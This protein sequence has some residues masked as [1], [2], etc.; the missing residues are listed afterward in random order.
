MKIGFHSHANK[1]NSHMKSKALSLT[2]TMRLR[3]AKKLAHL[4]M[5]HHEKN[6]IRQ[7]ELEEFLK[8]PATC[9]RRLFSGLGE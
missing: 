1:T 5:Y 2:F 6:V 9:S 3:R 8:L 4:N 7:M